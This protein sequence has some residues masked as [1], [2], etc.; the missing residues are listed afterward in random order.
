[1]FTMCQTPFSH[2]NSFSL[3]LNMI[4]LTNEETKTKKS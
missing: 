3:P 4:L 1:M 2:M